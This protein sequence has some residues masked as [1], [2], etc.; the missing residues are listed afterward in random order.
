MSLFPAEKL[1]VSWQLTT[2]NSAVKPCALH[3][4]EVSRPATPAFRRSFL[5]VRAHRWHRL[6][7]HIPGEYLPQDDLVCLIQGQSS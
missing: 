6:K 5:G 1:A 3:G 2:S 7:T 4:R